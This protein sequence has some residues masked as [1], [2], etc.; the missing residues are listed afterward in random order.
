MLRFKTSKAELT[1][2]PDFGGLIADLQLFNGVSTIALIDSYQSV[3]DA[4]AKMAYKS[5]YLLPFPNR[6]KDGKYE[7]EG[8]SY[9]FPINDANTNNNLHGFL[10]TISMEVIE[11]QNTENQQVIA[12][13]GNFEGLDY[14]PFPF[15]I[16]LKYT[17]SDSELIVDT[18]IKNTGKTNMPIGYGWHPYFKLDTEKVDDLLLQFPECD[19][20]EIDNRMMPTGETQPYTAFAEL[21]KINTTT[22]D[23]CFLLNENSTSNRAEIILK[24]ATTRL[25]VWQETGKNACNYFQIYIPENRKTIAIE[26]MTCN[27]DAFNNQNELWVLEANEARSVRFGVRCS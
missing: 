8:K 1:I 19:S 15:E 22:F 26:P 6:L 12:L 3:N 21:T 13:K 25:S 18:T 2:I 7:F 17:L 14:F 10:E 4:D 27:V 9:R 16:E 11:G 5:H 23:N 20:V 24:S